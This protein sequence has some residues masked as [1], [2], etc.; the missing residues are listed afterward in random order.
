MRIV[1][2]RVASASVTVEGETV[3]EIGPGL[4]ALV[5]VAHGDLPADAGRLA[6][7]TARLRLF[8]GD[9]GGPERSVEQTGGGVL[10]VSQ[11]TLLADTGKG[12]RPS[13]SAAAAPDV[14]APL[15]DVYAATLRGLGIP[16]ATGRFGARMQ[17]TLVNDGPVTLILDTAG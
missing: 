3:G 8:P 10:V 2:Q 15:V 14:A 7:K 17:V 16:V 4:L 5:G 6:E 1:L 11:F 9:D 12:N 13:W